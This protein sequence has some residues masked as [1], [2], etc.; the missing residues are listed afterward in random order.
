M[1]KSKLSA[2]ILVILLSLSTILLAPTET[3]AYLGDRTLTLGIQGYDVKQLQKDLGYLGYKV[4]N[5]DGIYGWQT[6][7]S[8]KEFQK[9]NGLTVDGVVGHQTANAIIKQVSQPT[10]PNTT[11]TPSRGIVSYS[12]QDMD[13]L[14][15][16]VYGEARGEPFE[17]Q[18]AV[19]AV[20]LNRVASPQFGDSIAEVIFEP[21]AFTAVADGQFY[22]KPDHTS[23]QAVQ[24]AL[25]GWDPSKNALYYW[26]PATATNKW[27]WTRTVVT[28]IGRHVFAR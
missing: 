22:L 12:N 3:M 7:L 20:V 27:V 16:L 26:N 17:G 11:S 8:V 23:Y 25:R 18:V 2:A 19:A 4:G 6:M 24:A 9:N 15:S 1:L 10:T 13:Y 28:Q 5:I 14:A 21:G